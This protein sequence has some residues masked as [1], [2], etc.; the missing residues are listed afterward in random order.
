M[1]IKCI[2]RNTLS[3]NL[4]PK[5]LGSIEQELCM[6]KLCC[7]RWI[8]V[9]ILLIGSISVSRLSFQEVDSGIDEIVK[10]CL[11]T[12]IFVS[13]TRAETEW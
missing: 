6:E 11:V 9:L 2:S 12:R 13:E 3:W 7:R 1:A 5:L 4:V 8:Y 10:A